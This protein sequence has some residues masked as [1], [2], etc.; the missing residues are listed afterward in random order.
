MVS[1]KRRVW[2]HAAPKPTADELISS[3]ERLNR[4]S[5]NFLKIDI[6]TALTFM[7]TARQTRDRERQERNVRAASR[8]YETVLNFMDRI[9]LGDE[10]TRILTTGLEQLRSELEGFEQRSGTPV[11]RPENHPLIKIK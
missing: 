1:K 10:D 2:G 9:V 3:C 7:D 5:A 8:A 11:A 4:A 6:Q